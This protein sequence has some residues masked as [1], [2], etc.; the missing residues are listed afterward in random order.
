MSGKQSSGE[1]KPAAAAEN[2][3][4]LDKILEGVSGNARSDEDSKAH[5]KELIEGYVTLLRDQKFAKIDKNLPTTIDK[6]VKA[7]DEKISEKL[8]TVVHDPAFLKLEGSWRGLSY[9]TTNTRVSDALKIRM[10]PVRKSELTRDFS[11]ELENTKLY[12]ALH[13][14]TYNVAGGQP[15]GALIGDYEWGPSQ[16]DIETLSSIAGVARRTF[17]PFITAASSTM[18]DLPS[19]DDLDVKAGANTLG[20]SMEGPQ[21]AKWRSFRETED[22][23]FVVMTLPRYL[24]R[25]PYGRDSKR[26]EEFGYEECKLGRDGQQHELEHN[27]YCWSNAAYAL[28]TK[29]TDAFDN[30]GFCTRIRGLDSGGRVSKLPLHTYT[31]EH[32]DAQNK[33]PTEVNLP[34]DFDAEF[35][36]LGFLPLIHY[37][38]TDVAVFMGGQT[39]RKP[40]KYDSESA[41]A[42]AEIS[43]RLPYVMATS[44]FAHNLKVMGRNMIGSFKEVTDVQFELDRWIKQYVQDNAS[45]QEYLKAKFPLREARVE[46]A[47][48]PG[49]PGAYNAIA[50]LRPW[51]QMEELNASLSMVAEIPGNRT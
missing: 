49:K 24:A 51:L 33:C 17:T 30:F 32:G 26:V 42:N 48:V 19:W 2:E 37:K 34:D 44:R 7:L 8:N 11:R 40:Q 50:Y 3:G 16:E 35:A 23:S 18:V 41:N 25:V 12:A 45:A 1:A 36:R 4:L 13:Q 15:F 6:L 29:L 31:T 46:V 47:P 10:M 22:A 43:A 5:A 21:F 9:L 38:D 27:Q 14:E 39:A 28:G 20:T